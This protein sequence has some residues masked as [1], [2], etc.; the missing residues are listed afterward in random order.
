MSVMAPRSSPRLPRSPTDGAIG[1]KPGPKPR[2]CPWT[3]GRRDTT[4]APPRHRG[5]VALL[6]IV[7]A[8]AG[9][10]VPAGGQMRPF[11]PIQWEPVDQRVA[12]VDLLAESF[13]AVEPGLGEPQG[14]DRVYLAPS[15]LFGDD[16]F[17]RINGALIA[18]FPRSIYAGSPYGPI[19]LVPAGTVYWIGPPLAWPAAT[20]ADE[21]EALDTAPNDH[22]LDLRLAD[23]PVGSGRYIEFGVSDGIERGRGARSWPIEATASIA[24]PAADR[25]TA[26]MGVGERSGVPRARVRALATGGGPRIVIDAEYR[27]RRLRSLLDAAARTGSGPSA[28]DRSDRPRAGGAD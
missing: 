27:A 1:P 23:A 21:Q 4:A 3:A 19:P 7:L 22:R 13:Q 5:T 17:A 9:V 26:S 14:F 11:E 8:L 20:A 15:D 18:T 16:R 25:S 12:D 6:A 24:S 10:V 28:A 2:R